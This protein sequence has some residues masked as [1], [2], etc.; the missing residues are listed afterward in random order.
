[1]MTMTILPTMRPLLVVLG[2]LPAV[3]AVVAAAVAG[4][5]LYMKHMDMVLPIFWLGLNVV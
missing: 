2:E 5:V 3:G 4:G 1:M